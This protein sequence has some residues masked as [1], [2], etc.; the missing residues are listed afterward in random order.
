MY[1]HLEGN[2]PGGTVD[3]TNRFDLRDGLIARLEIVPTEATEA[4]EA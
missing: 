1:T 3:L 2:F 4:A